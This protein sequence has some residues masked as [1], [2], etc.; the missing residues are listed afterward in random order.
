LRQVAVFQKSL[1][2]TVLFFLTRAPI[3]FSTSPDYAVN[4]PGDAQ[5]E[6]I[7]VDVYD[8]PAVHGAK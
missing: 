8:V 3:K 6:S 2:E 4:G 7:Q 5:L 1:G